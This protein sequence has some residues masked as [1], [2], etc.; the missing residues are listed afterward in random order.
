MNI[1]RT[2]ATGNSEHTKAPRSLFP[3][4]MIAKLERTK[5]YCKTK[6]ASNNKPP[7]T[8]GATTMNKQSRTTAKEQIIDEAIGGLK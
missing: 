8:M 1:Q 5:I 7:Q 3:C 6:Q 2:L 4:E